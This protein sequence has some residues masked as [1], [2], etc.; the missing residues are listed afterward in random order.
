MFRTFTIV[1]FIALFASAQVSHAQNDQKQGFLV[2]TKVI[3]GD[4]L[5]HMN[6]KEVVILPPHEFEN[7][8]EMLKYAKL[9][10]NIKKV[11][12]YA[13]L[14]KTRLIVIQNHLLELK[15]EAERKE[16]LKIAEQELKDEFEEE[17]TNLTMSQG[18][19]LIKLI[20]RET[21]NTSYALIK[22][23]KGS[24][25]AFLYQGLAR[26]FGENLKEEY[27][28]TGDDKLIE[29]IILR[30]ENGEF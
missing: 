18:R 30:I 7:K 15:T 6:F 20:D 26:L 2:Y 17:I 24:F 14:A 1:A 28:A 29:E 21:G 8:K 10:R 9:V 16:Y 12:P 13:K 22:D 3:D 27:D 11:L 5:P 23:L 25:S 19:L 4:T